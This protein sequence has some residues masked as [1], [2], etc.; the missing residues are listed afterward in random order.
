MFGAPVSRQSSRPV[1]NKNV[2]LHGESERWAVVRSISKVV[3]PD[4]RIALVAGDVRREG[5]GGP[6][7]VARRRRS[8]A[9][10][11]GIYA[12]RMLIGYKEL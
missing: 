6:L 11:T 5:R 1:R 4:L 3:G 2:P 7:D 9:G 12:Y 10:S 8:P